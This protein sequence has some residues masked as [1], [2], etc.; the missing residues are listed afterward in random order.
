M[1][2]N[3]A[4]HLSPSFLLSSLTRTALGRPRPNDYHLPSPTNV[5]LH[6][7]AAPPPI[8]EVRICSSFL[9]ILQPRLWIYL[10]FFWV[11]AICVSPF[12]INPV[13]PFSSH[14]SGELK[15]GAVKITSKMKEVC[16]NTKCL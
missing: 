15:G 8:A 2:P 9:L 5:D 16:D 14:V 11:A 7:E 3:F 13:M 10:Q 4:L 6:R 12:S 1:G